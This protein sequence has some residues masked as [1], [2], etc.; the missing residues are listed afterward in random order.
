[1]HSTAG[2]DYTTSS[3]TVTFQ[4]AEASQVVMVP[5]LF[6]NLLE[7]EEQFTAQLSR[8]ADQDGVVLGANTTTV[9]ITDD[10]CEIITSY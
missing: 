10:D 8:P 6:D 5:I 9:E 1:M 3:V 7:G 2:E 4:A